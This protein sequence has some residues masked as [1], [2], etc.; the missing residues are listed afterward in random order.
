MAPFAQPELPQALID[1]LT[2]LFGSRQFGELQGAVTPALEAHPNSGWLWQMYGLALSG[3]GRD[4]IAALEHAARLSPKTPGI[5]I[6]LGNALARAGRQA[7]AVTRYRRALALDSGI[8]EAH[9]NLAHCLFGLAQH[10]DA[11]ASY[12]QALQRK[13]GDEELIQHL[14][15]A[16]LGCGN[17]LRAQG[18]LEA[19]IAH[20]ESA[21]AISPDYSAA[22]SNLGTALRL[23]GLPGEASRVCLKAVE[24]DPKL[25]APLITLADIE[26]DCGDFIGAERRLRQAIAIE[27]DM[28]EAWAALAYVKRMSA[29]DS[30]WLDKVRELAGSGLPAPQETVLRYALGKSLDDAGQYAE[31]ASHYQRANVLARS[32]AARHDRGAVE[33]TV[34]AFVRRY[35]AATLRRL[36][37]GGLTSQQPVFIVG[38]VRSGTTLTEQILDAHP[39]VFG[40]G[41]LNFWNEVASCAPLDSESRL[42]VT[43]RSAAARYLELIG[44]L[45]SCAAR[46]VDKMPGNFMHLGLI[47]AALPG[48]RI[49]HMSRDPRDNA[50]SIY[51]QR[52][53]AM[54][55]Y[56]ND[57][58]DI[59]HFHSQYERLMAHWSAVLP[60]SAL[61]EVPYEGLVNDQKLWTRRMLEFI[62]LDWDPSCLNFERSVGTVRTA[63]NWQVRQGLNRG[64]IGRWRHYEQW[65]VPP[66]GRQ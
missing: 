22:H 48:A 40:A 45:A 25:L 17:S 2:A 6:N 12:E 59:A 66:S 13:P 49:I 26:A 28:P 18:R 8:V 4:P 1:E 16:H 3:Q 65:F 11:I 50:L 20:Y 19:A 64:S 9:I 47:H 31:A 15:A 52:F 54:H 60:A 62:G 44:T 57:L 29:E 39:R 56:A 34:D 37:A 21:V 55:T 53:E 61:L 23:A 51:F 38:M 46:V 27:C 32:F 42:A 24:L 43:V 35:D 63:S 41:E 5:H 7:D 30:L 14:A 33:R 10:D 58:E 36:R